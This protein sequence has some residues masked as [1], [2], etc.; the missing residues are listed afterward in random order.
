[1]H[2]KSIK[3]NWYSTLSCSS[4]SIHKRQI[5]LLHHVKHFIVN[6]KNTKYHE[7]L[8][9]KMNSLQMSC[10]IMY[11]ALHYNRFNSMNRKKSLLS[12]KETSIAKLYFFLIFDN[13]SRNIVKLFNNISFPISDSF[14]SFCKYL[15][16]EIKQQFERLWVVFFPHFLFLDKITQKTEKNTK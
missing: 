16:C 4:V 3:Y 13:N 5:F 7:Y 14:R 1:M 6:K 9:F 12:S 11:E 8:L 2:Y 15:L 10:S